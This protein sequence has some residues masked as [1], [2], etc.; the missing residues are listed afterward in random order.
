[1]LS[2]FLQMI[3]SHQYD[4]FFGVCIFLISAISYNLGKLNSNPKTTI[5]ISSGSDV[6]QASAIQSI[7]SSDLLATPIFKPKDLRVIASKNSTTKKYHY[8]W[9]PGA[10]KIKEENKIWFSSSQ[11]A[12]SGGY[13]LAGNCEL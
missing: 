9:C 6:F 8:L 5:K 3:K 10:K 4:I 12:E 11:E 2:K 1:M 7:N 13:T